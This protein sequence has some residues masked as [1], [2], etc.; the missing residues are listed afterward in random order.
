MA[1]I[2]RFEDLDVWKK[3]RA[4]CQKVFELMQKDAFS[5][6]YELKNQISRSAGSTM[7]N[8]SEGFERGGNREFIQFLGYS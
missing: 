5:K 6:D 1:T 3:A 4:L 7:D 2:K 8:I